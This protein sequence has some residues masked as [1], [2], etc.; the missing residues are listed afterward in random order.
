MLLIP[1][2][3]FVMGKAGGGKATAVDSFPED[4]QERFEAMSELQGKREK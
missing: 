1:A 3:S 2:G 4:L